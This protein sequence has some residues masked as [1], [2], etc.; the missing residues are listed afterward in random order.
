MSSKWEDREVILTNRGIAP[1]VRGYRAISRLGRRGSGLPRR[2][3]SNVWRSSRRSATR[4]DA[5]GIVDF[6]YEY[7]NHAYCKLVDL[8]VERLVGRPAGELFPAFIGSGRFALYREVAITGEPAA[9]EQLF[10]QDAWVGSPLTGRVFDTVIAS[11]GENI[12]VCAREVTDRVNAERAHEA[13]EA[14]LRD[15]IE[16]ATDAMV[17][18]NVEGEIVLVNAQTEKLF[19][20]AREELVGQCQ[21]LLVP[22]LLR[23]R[24]RSRRASYLTDPRARPMGAGL[25]LFARRKDGSEFPVEISLSPRGSEDG[26][27]VSCAIRDITTRKQAEQELALRAELLALAHDAVIVRESAESRVRFWNREA[28]AVYGNSAAEAT[29]RVTHE[30]LATVFPDSLQAVDEALARDGHW[31]GE[32]RHVRKDG[33]ELLVSSRQALRRDADGR[34]RNHPTGRPGPH[35]RDDR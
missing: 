24:H 7:A 9:D 6:R 16:S 12:V 11:T 28:H 31:S 14:R 3:P 19:G 29:G 18:V 23:D 13:A 4:D 2:R 25:E 1:S 35:E 15:V 21:E 32:L 27:L 5:D 10:D 22:K 8:G 34:A 17:I 33:S 30:L 26:T 20:F